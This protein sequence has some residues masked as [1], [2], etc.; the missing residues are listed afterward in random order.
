MYLLY[1]F[2]PEL[3]TLPRKILLVVLQIGKGKDLSAPP[4]TQQD[5]IYKVVFVFYWVLI[6]FFQNSGGGWE[7][8]PVPS[9][10]SNTHNLSDHYLST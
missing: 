3:H 7:D 6:Y 8:M 4:C 9:C 1:I 10:A 2:L 5:A